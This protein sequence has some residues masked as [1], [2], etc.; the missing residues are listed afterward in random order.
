MSTVVSLAS[1]DRLD[2]LWEDYCVLAQATLDNPSL[3]VD[4]L[5]MEAQLRALERFRRALA[6]GDRP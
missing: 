2:R 5:H 4:R 6:V 3:T 1:P